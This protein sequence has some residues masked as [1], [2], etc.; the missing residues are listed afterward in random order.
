[1]KREGAALP[2]CTV[3]YFFAAPQEQLPP[4]LH[5]F[6][7]AQLGPQMQAAALVQPHDFFSHRHSFALAIG[8][9]SV[10]AGRLARRSHPKTQALARHYT[11]ALRT[12]KRGYLL[13]PD[14][15]TLGRQSWPC[16]RGRP[17]S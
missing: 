17:S 5:S 6:L 7:H 11:A 2:S 14:R 9:S 10:V 8:F 4:Q 16:A 3:L 15:S 13:A 12:R 1:M